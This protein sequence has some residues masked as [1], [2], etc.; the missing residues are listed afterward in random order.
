MLLIFVLSIMIPYLNMIWHG[1][2]FL[3]D[4]IIVFLSFLSFLLFSLPIALLLILN[5]YH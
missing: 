2:I 5:L 4:L 3:M 1:L